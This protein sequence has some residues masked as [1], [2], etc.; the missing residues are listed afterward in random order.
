MILDRFDP[1]S[2]RKTTCGIQAVIPGRAAS[3]N[4]ESSGKDRARG[5]IP[6]P[7]CGR[8]GMTPCDVRGRDP[9]GMNR[10]QP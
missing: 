2:P 4:P 5:W 1:K 3:A 6:G 8:P 9:A 7:A 10:E